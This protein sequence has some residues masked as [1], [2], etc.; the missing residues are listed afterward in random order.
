MYDEI[1]NDVLKETTENDVND[2]VVKNDASQE[3]KSNKMEETVSISA[4]V[5]NDEEK[6]S[7]N[8]FANE[9]EVIVHSTSQKEA[10]ITPEKVNNVE[11]DHTLQSSP[12]KSELTE[13]VA[14][15]KNVESDQKPNKS[16]DTQQH[17]PEH[18][19][20]AVADLKTN[21]T[22]I[23]PRGSPKNSPLNSRE[24]SRPTSRNSGRI[25][26]DDKILPGY[27]SRPESPCIQDS[28][29]DADAE[30]SS[31]LNT[32]I[33]KVTENKV[34][35]ESSSRPHSRLSHDERLVPGAVS[36]PASE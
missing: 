22:K 23:S 10:P 17:S 8:S 21:E 24:S 15:N 6:L 4:N 5:K 36:M 29:G 33:S 11:S 7:N 19:T 12:A 9:N 27:M 3:E 28:K 2:T 14:T 18:Q 13:P 16:K 20:K 1:Q 34:E 26:H 30:V 25:S 35:S 31:L 32:V